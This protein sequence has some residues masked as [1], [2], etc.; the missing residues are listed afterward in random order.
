MEKLPD[1]SV[2]PRAS[3][4]RPAQ[5]ESH[6]AGIWYII[7]R[8]SGLPARVIRSITF[9]ATRNVSNS[10]PVANAHFKSDAGLDSCRSTM[11]SPN[12]KT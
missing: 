11:A 1:A 7:T 10:T 9:P 3:G 6:T 2:W 4:R 5:M 8:K 12:A